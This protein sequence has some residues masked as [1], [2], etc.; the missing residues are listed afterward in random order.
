VVGGLDGR[1]RIDTDAFVGAVQALVVDAESGG[2]LDAKTGEVVADVGGPGD[3]GRAR[4]QPA[5]QR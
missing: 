2:R 3:L 5:A 4:A 1:D